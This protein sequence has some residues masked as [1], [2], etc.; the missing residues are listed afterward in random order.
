M[1]GA[2]VGSGVAVSSGAAV[3][4]TGV[5]GGTLRSVVMTTADA[6]VC[7]A[8]TGGKA[9]VPHGDGEHKHQLHEP[10]RFPQPCRA[11]RVL[12]RERS[13]AASSAAMPQ[14]TSPQASRTMLP[15]AQAQPSSTFQ[16][17]L[18]P[19]CIPISPSK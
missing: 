15:T 11:R 16:M 3:S 6:G 1:S 2:G 10:P 12:Q 5:T 4:G 13:A 8:R 14:P 17:R 7:A 18:H 19:I 9:G